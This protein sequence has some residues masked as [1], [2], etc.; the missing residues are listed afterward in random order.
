MSHSFTVAG[1][2]PVDLDEIANQLRE[3]IDSLPPGSPPDKLL[4]ASQL[5]QQTGVAEFL[6]VVRGNEDP[7]I[8]P[9][10][11]LIVYVLE[12]GGYFQLSSTRVEATEGSVIVI[13]KG[14]CHA[15]YNLS[16]T[17]SVLMATFSPINSKAACPPIS[18]S[19]AS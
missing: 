14:V 19:I 11:D 4:K 17:D 6:V 12:G 10:G 13:P 15:Y 8:H 3:E 5:D 18:G 7:H 16:E 1:A 2:E 9:E